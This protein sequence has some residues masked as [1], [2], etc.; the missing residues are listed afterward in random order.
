MILSIAARPL[1]TITNGSSLLNQKCPLLVLN[2]KP[3][4]KGLIKKA[5]R[6]LTCDSNSFGIIV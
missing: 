4:K 5:F 6:F 2:H 3:L 1:P